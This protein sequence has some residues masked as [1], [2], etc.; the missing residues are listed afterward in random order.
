MVAA[1]GYRCTS[2]PRL[3]PG[4]TKPRR[5]GGEVG[6][7]FGTGFRE[8]AWSIGLRSVGWVNDSVTHHRKHL[9]K[10]E[11]GGLRLRLTNFTAS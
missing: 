10:T 7:T 1:G 8:L 11:R 9:A 6:A 4:L 2:C 5:Y 3:H